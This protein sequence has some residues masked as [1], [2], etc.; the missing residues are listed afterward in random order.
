MAS[1]SPSTSGWKVAVCV[2]GTVPPVLQERCA[3]VAVA[4][5]RTKPKC[6]EE[7]PFLEQPGL[8]GPGQTPASTGR[9]A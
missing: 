5:S 4:V 3:L 8:T 2:A 7:I 9:A 6:S 1:F